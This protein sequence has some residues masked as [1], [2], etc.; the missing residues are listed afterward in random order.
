MCEHFDADSLCE[1]LDITS[2]D[3]FDALWDYDKHI[4]KVE[5]VLTELDYDSDG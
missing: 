5:D 3:I 1:L 4:G 2:E